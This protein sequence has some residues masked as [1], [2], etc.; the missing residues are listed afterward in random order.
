MR[1]GRMTAVLSDAFRSQEPGPGETLP[2]EGELRDALESIPDDLGW[3]WARPRLTPLFERANADGIVGDPALHTVTPLGVAVGYGIETGPTFLRVSASMA[4]RWEASLE[5]IEAAAFEHLA[6][7]VGA[8]GPRH[9]Q[10]A[11]H[12]G[13]LARCLPEP[14]GWASSAILAGEEEVRRIFGG[15]DQVF[16]VPTR[17]MLMAFDANVP[18]HAVGTV[19]AMI[20]DNDPH[21]L[22]LDAFVMVDGLLSWTGL[23]ATVGDEPL[24]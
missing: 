19:T 9:L 4:Q 5:Q 11:V 21:P 7:A 15:H 23:A 24:A 12:R 13:H 3:E 17:N 8:V 2:S 6:L 16:T 14:G 10:H 20:E 22:M 1:I 18:A